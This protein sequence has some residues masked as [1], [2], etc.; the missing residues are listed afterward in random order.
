MPGRRLK[1]LASKA[2]S[3]SL[4]SC[5]ENST[6]DQLHYA[7]VLIITGMGIISQLT[8]CSVRTP[9]CLQAEIETIHQQLQSQDIYLHTEGHMIKPEQLVQNPHRDHVSHIYTG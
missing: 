7:E 9:W 4:T 3:Q 2:V 8:Q 1:A 5:S 6:L